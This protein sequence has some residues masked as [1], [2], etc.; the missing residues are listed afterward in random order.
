M[1]VLICARDSEERNE[2]A[3]EIHRLAHE[4]L[5][6]ADAGEAIRLVRLCRPEAVILGLDL[7]REG[8]REVLQF[9]RKTRWHDPTLVMT[10]E[11]TIEDQRVFDRYAAGADMVLLRPLNPADL[12]IFRNRH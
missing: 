4:T 1:T 10:L 8:G 6:A 2:L 7:D 12:T 5:Q 11:D 3:R 9:I